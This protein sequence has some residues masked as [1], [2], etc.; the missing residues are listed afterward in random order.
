[1]AGATAVTAVIGDF[2][3]SF[4]SL[5]SS[6][7]DDFII[8]SPHPAPSPSAVVGRGGGAR[9]LSSALGFKALVGGDRLTEQAQAQTEGR[10]QGFRQDPGSEMFILPTPPP[11]PATTRPRKLERGGGRG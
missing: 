3:G 9:V 2:T 5:A 11:T 7:R 1:M 4:T 8:P 10:G 6:F